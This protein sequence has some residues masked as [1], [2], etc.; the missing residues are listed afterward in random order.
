MVERKI[1]YKIFLSVSDMSSVLIL[2]IR[3]SEM[4]VSTEDSTI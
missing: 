2:T 1:M 3:N 4:I